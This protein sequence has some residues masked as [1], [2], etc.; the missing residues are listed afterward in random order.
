MTEGDTEQGSF[1]DKGSLSKHKSCQITVHPGNH[2][3]C[4]GSQVSGDPALAF[5]VGQKVHGAYGRVYLE[6]TSPFQSKLW[7]SGTLKFPAQMAQYLLPGP[8]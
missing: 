6:P 5:P 1:D 3:P 4:S 8:T 2:Y 7:V